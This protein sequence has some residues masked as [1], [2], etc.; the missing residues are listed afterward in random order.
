MRKIA[1]LIGISA[2]FLL[3]FHPVGP[4]PYKVR[5]IVIDAGH[6]KH[7][8]G[9]LGI[10]SKEKDVA[11]KIALELGRILEEKMPDVKVIF[12]RKTDAFL[13]LHERAD[14]ANK[15]GADLFI[16]IHCNSFSN[17]TVFGT[18]TYVMGLD[19]THK[20]LDV[21]KR[22]NASI[23]LEENHETNYDG[24]DPDS[25]E[26]Y[27]LFALYQNAYMNQSLDLGARIEKEMKERA[28]RNSRGVRQ[29]PFLVLWRTTMPSVLVETGYLSNAKEEKE[30]NDALNQSYI[31]SGI[32]RAIRSYR[33]ELEGTK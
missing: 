31:A 6:G 4:G 9:T 33:E 1:L 19:K 18:E 10:I 23:L 24:F 2:L 7:D 22:E 20:N 8:P 14:V 26:S 32:Y 17:K 3:A 5:K 15:N 29:A 30:L 28:G 11:L 16:S 21:A 12:T 25:D 13:E 27:I